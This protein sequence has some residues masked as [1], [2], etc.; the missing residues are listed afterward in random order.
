MSLKSF[1]F[2]MTYDYFTWF[3]IVM[4]CIF[5]SLYLRNI[6]CT[7]LVKA[8]VVINVNYLVSY[9]INSGLWEFAEAPRCFNAKA[10]FDVL[11][12]YS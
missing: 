5:I 12:R 11:C 1:S 2:Y 9:S 4:N 6:S 3:Y 8:S 10:T 7:M